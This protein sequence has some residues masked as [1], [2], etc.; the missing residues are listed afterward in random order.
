MLHVG[1]WQEKYAVQKKLQE[2]AETVQEYALEM[3][4]IAETV[5]QKYGIEF[6]RAVPEGWVPPE[7]PSELPLCVQGRF[8]LNGLPQ[9]G[10][11][12]RR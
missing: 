5:E 3:T 12:N 2:R 11:F 1:P 10:L 7:L 6:L 4:R 9:R 8:C